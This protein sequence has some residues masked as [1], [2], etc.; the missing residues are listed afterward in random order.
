M[1]HESFGEVSYP[2]RY[3]GKR[4]R[5]EQLS[6]SYITGTLEHIQEYSGKLLLLLN[7]GSEDPIAVNFD[8]VVSI[9][10]AGTVNRSL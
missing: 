5:I 1:S 7:V 6:G 3:I 9:A 4:V 2:A 8:H 10:T